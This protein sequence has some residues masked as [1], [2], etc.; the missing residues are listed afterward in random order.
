MASDCLWSA[1]VLGMLEP[2]DDGGE[3]GC[4]AKPNSFLG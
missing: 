4:V 3:A 1:W 2:A